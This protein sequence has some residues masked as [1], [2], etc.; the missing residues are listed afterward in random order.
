MNIEFW[1][2]KW[3]KNI[4]GFHLS[5]VNPLLVKF[6]EKLCLNKNDRLFLPLCGKT[7]DISWLLSKGYN[8]VG[9]EFSQL[10]VKQLFDEL[11]VEP[12]IIVLED[13]IHYSA[14]GL[15]IYV[16]DF[17]KLTPIIL[18]SVDAVYDRAALVAL[19]KSMRE[20]Y[21]SHLREITNEV[22]QLLVTFMYDENLLKGPPFSVSNDEV[23]EHYEKQYKIKLLDNLNKKFKGKIDAKESVWLLKTT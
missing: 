19:P 16:G 18:G 7:K 12:K 6:Y 22:P 11:E 23:Y 4:I 21:A 5:E 9:V 8:I 17:F 20:Q 2:D 3:E 15:D 1:K 13:L 10:A 14:Q